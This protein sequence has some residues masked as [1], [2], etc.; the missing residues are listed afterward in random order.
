MNVTSESEWNLCPSLQW[1]SVP[2]VS[3]E[4]QGVMGNDARF[5]MDVIMQK[6]VEGISLQSDVK[7]ECLMWP[8]GT[9]AFSC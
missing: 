1:H 4:M 5:T 6:Q 7:R 2:F 9:A 8:L 3:N